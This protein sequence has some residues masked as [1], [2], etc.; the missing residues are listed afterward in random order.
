[1]LGLTKRVRE[2][3]DFEGS[4]DPFRAVVTAA[5]GAP[6]ST[7]GGEQSRPERSEIISVVSHQVPTKYKTHV[8][9][10]LELQQLQQL[11]VN[12]TRN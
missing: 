6:D 1:M 11:I 10:I 4:S 3:I 8:K 12:L 9:M 2:N 7:V 5:A